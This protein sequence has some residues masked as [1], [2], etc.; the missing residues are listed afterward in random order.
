MPDETGPSLT[1]DALGSIGMLGPLG[2]WLSL[3]TKDGSGNE[4]DR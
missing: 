4:E 3:V 2:W 1:I